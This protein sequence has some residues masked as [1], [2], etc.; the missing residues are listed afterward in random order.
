[1]SLNYIR[2]FTV[3]ALIMSSALNAEELERR[4]SWQAKFKFN[5][6]VGIELTEVKNDTPL[7]KAGLRKG[8]IIYALNDIKITSRPALD[9][10]TDSL[11]AE[12]P[13]S[14][15]FLKNSGLSKASVTF[16]PQPK[17]QYDGVDVIYD[18][19]YNP[20]GYYQRTI[21]SKPKNRTLPMPAII[22]IQGL[23]CS[24]IEYLPGRKSNF[25]RTITDIVAKS[26]MVVMRIE[27]PGMGDSQGNCSLTDFK[28]ELQGYELAIEQL[29]KMPD[30]DSKRIVI[31]GSSMGSALAPYLAEKFELNGVVAEGTFFRSWFEHM[32]EIERRIKIM[33]GVNQQEL[34]Q[35]MINAYIPLYYGMLVE[36]KSYAQVI[37]QNS[38]LAEYNYHGLEH[39]YGRPMSYYHQL[40]RFNFAGHWEKLSVPVKIRRG[41]NDW[42]MSDSDNNMIVQA[43][44]KAGNSD[45][46]LYRYE[47]LDHWNTVH[48]SAENSFNGEPG[49][50]QDKISDQIVEW[51]KELN[52][53][54][55]RKD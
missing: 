52:A 31:F 54:S 35:Q 45:V 51:A 21:I 11:V 20:Y 24:S 6:P 29:K 39:M 44:K 15:T 41:T 26:N 42:I 3:F 47:G 40:Q 2:V 43:L 28:S 9:D 16:S 8:H 32:L 25:I 12:K 55:W 23:S 49:E 7:Y 17:E 38:L 14:I 18:E 34:N 22:I 1:M 30:V 13:Y 46:E 50:W 27:K 37:Q 48:T 5:N 36:Q 53:E 33:Q 19:I 4:A 10:L